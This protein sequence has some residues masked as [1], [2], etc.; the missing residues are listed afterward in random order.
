MEFL[1]SWTFMIIMA[2]LLC[3]LVLLIPVG[4]L[5]AIFFVHRANRENRDSRD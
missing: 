1:Q 3:F 5:L 2:G 4:I